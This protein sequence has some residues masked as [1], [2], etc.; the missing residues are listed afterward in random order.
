MF[1]KLNF[2]QLFE[3]KTP[4]DVKVQ[5]HHTYHLHLNRMGS[6]EEVSYCCRHIR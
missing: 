4:L 3:K 1:E 2:I 6:I 5:E